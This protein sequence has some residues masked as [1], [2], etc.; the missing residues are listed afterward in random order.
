MS[1]VVFTDKD[2]MERR[3]ERNSIPR[4]KERVMLNGIYL[5]DLFSYKRTSH[6]Y[7]ELTKLSRE[8][9]IEKYK[10]LK[11]DYYILKYEEKHEN[12]EQQGNLLIVFLKGSCRK[13]D[14]QSSQVQMG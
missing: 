4:R 2:V 13:L 6:K 9:K 1:K 12:A 10:K 7:K 14:G 3:Q 5:E 11:K 8:E